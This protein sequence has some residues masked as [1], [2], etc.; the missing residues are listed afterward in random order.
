MLKK[1]RE[2]LAILDRQNRELAERGCELVDLFRRQRKPAVL[3]ELQEQLWCALTH[4]EDEIQRLGERETRRKARSRGVR[5]GPAKARLRERRLNVIQRRRQF[6]EERRMI[7][8]HLG[9]ACAWMVLRESTRFVAP[10]HEER[11]HRLPRGHGAIGPRYVMQQAHGTGEFFVVNTDL[12]R[13]SGIGDLI[14]VPVNDRW[15]SPLI[16]EVK[17]QQAVEEAITIKL[18]F[19]VPENSVDLELLADFCEKVGFRG[20]PAKSISTR[21]TKRQVEEM[22]SR[23]QRVVE[24]ITSIGGTFEPAQREHWRIIERVL[25]RA[26]QVGAAYDIAEPDVFFA[27]VRNEIQDNCVRTTWRLL[28]FVLEGGLGINVENIAG[29]SSDDFQKHTA[30]SALVPPIP[31][32]RLPLDLRVQLLNGEIVFFCFSSKGVWKNAFSSEG[33]ELLERE[34]YWILSRGKAK[35]RLDPIETGDLTFGVIFSGI[36]PRAV[37]RVIAEELDRLGTDGSEPPAMVSE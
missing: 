17:T 13:C 9:D 36:S 25:R 5:L 15:I 32:W 22:Q 31:M 14:V 33:V 35:F 3:Q 10:L 1:A 12:T 2:V 26:K 6:F 29:A 34:D 11:S 21:K 16:L 24:L 19:P 20:E 7:L 30:L 4:A 8:R 23:S 28:D 37:A 18:H 27:G